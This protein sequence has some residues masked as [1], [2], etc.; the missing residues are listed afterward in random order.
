MNSIVRRAAG[1]TA[2]VTLS[3][4]LVACADEANDEIPPPGAGEETLPGGL[5]PTDPPVIE[6]TEEP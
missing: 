4:A 1:V 3:A 5:V 6:P 2:A